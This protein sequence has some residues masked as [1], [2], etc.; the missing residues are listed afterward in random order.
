ML[1]SRRYLQPLVALCF[2][3]F[4]PVLQA[5]EILDIDDA[6]VAEA[7]PVAPVMGGYMKIENETNK[8]ISITR[9]SCPEFDAVE[10]HEM[11]MSGG[12]MKMREIEK[13]DIP[14]GGKVELKPGGY[15]LMLIK[16]KKPF[17][18]GDTLTV[19][20]HTADGQSQAVKMEVKERKAS[21]DHQHHHH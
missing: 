1:I 3:L 18:K 7:P 20:L 15:H 4:V 5:D 17:K 12:M 21:D 9:A 14:A 19:T 8:P 13:L 11:S 6:W 16:P 10:I 2:L